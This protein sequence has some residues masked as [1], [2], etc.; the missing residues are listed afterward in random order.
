MCPET[1]DT[2]ILTIRHRDK[3]HLLTHF[4][5]Y[6]HTPKAEQFRVYPLP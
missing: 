2:G 6:A 5:I 1:T 3:G 4:Q